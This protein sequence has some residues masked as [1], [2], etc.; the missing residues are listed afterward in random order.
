[1]Q[2]KHLF[3]ILLCAV[4]LSAS[5]HQGVSFRMPFLLPQHPSGRAVLYCRTAPHTMVFTPE[6]RHM[7]VY[8]TQR[9]IAFFVLNNTQSMADVD[10]A[11]QIIRDSSRVWHLNPDDIG[12]M[13]CGA[14]G[15][16][17]ARQSCEAPWAVRPNFTIML[18]PLLATPPQKKLPFTVQNHLTPPAIVLVAN[19]DAEISP[20]NNGVAYYTAMRKAGNPCALHV[21]PVQ[22]KALLQAFADT[23][24]SELIA[25][26][27]AWLKALPSPQIGAIRVACIGNSITDGMGID[28]NDVHSYPARLQQLLGKDYYVRNFGVSA[29]TL[30]NSGDRPYMRE[31]AWQMARD[32][33]PDIVIIK[34]GT[35]DSKPENWQHGAAFEHDLQAMVDTLQQLPSHPRILLATPIP[36][37]K[38][39]WNINDSVLVHAITPIIAKVAREKHCD[40]IDLHQL[41]GLTSNDVQPDGIHPTATGAARIAETIYSFITQKYHSTSTRNLPK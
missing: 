34:L 5:A 35:N 25:N 36:A 14:E 7:A 28:L 4:G 11:M 15:A 6:E 12:M 17:V 30:L 29:R 24:H 26:L 2:M 20:V 3:I 41:A 10:Y 19:D 1:M 18:S 8:F 16:L 37:F 39:T 31:Q 21:Y 38:P 32:F 27:S 23:L 33:A 13:G 9:G 40:F 22:R